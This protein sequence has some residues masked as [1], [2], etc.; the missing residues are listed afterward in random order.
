MSTTQAN[1]LAIGVEMSVDT[2]RQLVDVKG[3]VWLTGVPHNS[4]GSQRVT[5]TD[6][7]IDGRPESPAFG[8]LLA[9]AQSDRVMA[10]LKGALSQDFARD[11]AKVIT[12]ATKAISQKRVGDFV[13]K[14]QVDNVINGAVVPVGQGLY[15]PVDV[16]GKGALTFDPEPKT[17]R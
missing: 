2:P 3:T 11:Y 15:M 10:Q 5:V 12:A 13:V 16:T 8:V 4:P 9:V 1:R 7:R 6:L 17:T 14:A